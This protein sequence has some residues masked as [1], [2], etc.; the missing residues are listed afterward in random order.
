MASP[1]NVAYFTAL[2]DQVNAATSC[3]Q[4]QAA[5]NSAFPAILAAQA[6][7]TAQLALITPML[8]LLTAPAS[9]PG[10]IVTWI[11][12][13][14]ENYLT[15]QLVPAV[16]LASQLTETIAAIASLTSAIESA[17]AKFESCSITIPS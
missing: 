3:A 12:S 8:A 1:I 17:A 10:A 11:T 4:L 2:T 6:A 5:V 7:A 9:N 13:L 15:P 14:I 16:T